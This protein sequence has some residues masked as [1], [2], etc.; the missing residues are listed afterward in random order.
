MKVITES[1]KPV[2]ALDA[3]LVQL[4]VCPLKARAPVVITRIGPLRVRVPLAVTTWFVWAEIRL[5]D[6]PPL[7]RVMFPATISPIRMSPGWALVT[8]APAP[9][10]TVTLP[11]V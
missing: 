3:S 11:V 8:P 4:I 2:R 1:L 5:V 9:M 7:S 6:C 10:V